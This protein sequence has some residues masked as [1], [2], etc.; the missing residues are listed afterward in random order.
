M[1]YHNKFTMN[2]GMTDQVLFR[3]KNETASVVV[4][5][6]QEMTLNDV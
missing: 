5:V 6:S 4:N 3:P 1:Y 2:I